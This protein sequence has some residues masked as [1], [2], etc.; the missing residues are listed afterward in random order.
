ME[1][2]MGINV[3]WQ[4]GDVQYRDTLKY[5]VERCY[6]HALDNLQCLV[7]QRLFELQRMNLS[8]QEYKMR[9]HITKALQTRCRAIRR[10]ITAYNSAAANLTLPCPSLNWKDVSRYSFIEEFTIL[11][12][13]RHDIRQ[14]PWAEPAVCVLMKNARCIK[15]ARTEIIH[16]NVEVRRIHTAIVDESRF[17]HSTLA[18]LQQ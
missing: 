4:P 8:Q 10:A 16:C 15:N 17:F 9:S 2:K 1:V 11:W 12:D 13:T 18:H 7:I 5:V 3:R 14:H 6:H